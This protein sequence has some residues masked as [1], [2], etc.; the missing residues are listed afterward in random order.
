MKSKTYALAGLLASALAMPFAAHATLYSFSSGD[1]AATADFT[2]TG[3]GQLQVVLTN[4]ST[5]DVEYPNQVLTALFFD[6]NSSVILTPDTALLT[7]GST[8]FS[9]PDGQPVGGNVGGEWAYNTGFYGPN[10]A[11]SGISSAG[12]SLFGAANFNGPD[13]DNMPASVDGFGYGISSAGDII[14]NQDHGNPIQTGT[15][16][17]INNSVTFLF[18]VTGTPIDLDNI[19]HMS[20]QYGTSLSEPNIVPIP[21]AAWLFGSALL[22]IAGVGYRRQAKQ[23]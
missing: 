18:N 14:G 13:L 11:N 6:V 5:Q 17:L 15:V 2:L 1:L 9:D 20:V 7:A 22:G 16:P 21:A 19:Q 23:G 3:G 8:V 4:T 10:G 12:F